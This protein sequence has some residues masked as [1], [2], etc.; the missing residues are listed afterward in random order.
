[1]F[2][3]SN[4]T[5]PRQAESLTVEQALQQ[6]IACH[7]SGQLQDA[8]RLYRSI[9]QVQPDHPDANHNLGVLAMQVKQPAAGLAHFKAA[10]DANP[11]QGQYWLSYIDA[12][13]QAGQTDA[14]RQAMAAGRQQGLQGEALDALAGRLGSEPAADQTNAG[15]PQTP[16]EPLPIS[17]PLPQQRK[18]KLKATRRRADTS[19]RASVSREGKGPSLEEIDGLV[20]LF[21]EGRYKEAA[22]LAHETTV[23][24]P[25]HGFG[26]KLLGASFKQMGRGE[27][28]LAPLE[29]AA[30][31]SPNDA[32]AHYN[33]GLTL[34]DLGRLAEAEASY[35][36]AVEASP[37]LAEAHNNLGTTLKDMRR[38]DDAAASLRRALQI[39]PDYAEAHY[40]LGIALRGLGQ[41][42]EAAASYRR[43]LEIKPS[44]VGAHNN[45]GNIFRDM[46][47]LDAA[48][49]CLR[50]ALKIKPDF[51][52]AH[53]NLGST[54]HD[55]GQLDEAEPSFRQALRIKPGYAEA[56]NNL[57]KT[58]K[59]LGRLDEAE[60]CF[61][62][63]LD[64]KPD[65]AGAHSNRGATLHDL[66][67]LD[68]AEA[69]YRRVMEIE[70]D[71]AEAHNNLGITLERLGRLDEA[72][73]SYRRALQTMPRFADAFNNLAR[74]L[75]T[76]G[77]SIM[78]LGIIRQSLEIKETG[79]AKNIF[80]DCVER[81]RWTHDNADIR[82]LMLRALTELWGRPNELVRVSTQLVKLNPNIAECIARA[83]GAWPKQLS[84]Q[85]L[86]GA[87]DLASLAADPLLCALLDSAPICDIEMERFLTMTR[88]V[89]LDMAT[90]MTNSA[91]EVGAAL[92][93][94][95]ALARQCFV[96]EYVFAH[97]EDE[98]RKAAGLR[99]SL[100]AA[101]QAKAQVPVSWLL[102][103][104]AY[105][106]LCTLPNAARLLDTEWPGA[107]M[108]VLLQ[109]ILE[110]AEE[111]QLRTTIPRLT[112]IEDDV[113]LLVQNQYEE[114]PYP[115][116]VRAA[117]VGRSSNIV[118]YLCQQF[119]LA[120]FDRHSRSGSIDVL[121]AGCGTGQHSILAARQFQ[122][123]R[124]LAVDLSMSSLSY[125]KRKTR[126][127]G[128]T[129][130]EY[131]QADLLKLTSLD[132]SFDVIESV[133]VLHHLGDAWAGWRILLSLLRPDGFM[134]LGFYSEI[135][136]RNIVEAR[137]F[138]A[139]QGY[140][141]AANE[142]RRCRQHLMELDK[143]EDLSAILRSPDFYS[144][145]A[146]RD[147]LFHVQEHRMSLTSID[148]FLRD[149]GLTFL[150]FEIDASVLHAYAQRFPDD[151]AATDLGH[152]QLFE[153]DNPDTFL[154]M[155]QFWIQKAD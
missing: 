67:R 65:F 137:A 144:T 15:F 128:L 39:K 56:Y 86:L 36:R 49:H 43:T 74:L 108:D 123:A 93:F 99:D 98:I 2:A 61:R 9:L 152:W 71:F 62:L 116:W 143:S 4:P 125:A 51:A 22:A 78:A 68:Q 75:N 13:L 145:S 135:A 42:E 33:L 55:L 64:I 48:E 10:L 155:Y 134:K 89:M 124:V 53:Y 54:L 82:S 147:L 28:A 83:A 138:I 88:R 148:A 95:S 32:Q 91:G 154:G 97:S 27:D 41:L 84:A 90:G 7:R 76:Q 121:I 79:E 30:A 72:E 117:P 109:Q 94:Y 35:Q 129:S 130:I 18:K 102:A 69:S 122:A 17:P 46:G 1:M 140:G 8:E 70:P 77:R 11:A 150:G 24:Y 47:R 25:Q 106:P 113:S 58:L 59:D 131:A 14:A 112:D 100:I 16:G 66:G 133:G 104:A 40:N 132:L 37:D 127:L 92:S 111:L 19:S 136:R 81:L 142:I 110:P 87:K 149:N 20:A 85:E 6:A 63:A 114:N 103:V 153:N 115:R 101:L 12:L 21:T 44:F 29:K 38:L 126:E 60:D 3:M 141:A 34:Y 139:G 119:P 52:E 5:L 26:W 73:A 107:V 105:F 118:G 31:L 96:N 50:Q 146:C 45:L 57:G 120:A 23:H 151:R 80:V